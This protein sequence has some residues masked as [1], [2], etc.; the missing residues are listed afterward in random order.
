MSARMAWRPAAPARNPGILMIN[1]ATLV[2]VHHA[3]PEERAV[4]PRR[5][6]L[7]G[8]PARGATGGGLAIASDTLLAGLRYDR[9]WDVRTLPFGRWNEGETVAVKVLHQLVD[10]A[11][12]PFRLL[13]S[14]PALVHLQSSLDRRAVLRD[15]AFALATRALGV[16]LVVMWHGS[17]PDLLTTRRLPWRA[18][19]D[20]LLRLTNAIVLLSSEERAALV[21]H[22]RAPHSRVMRNGL[23]L[24]RYEA[25]SDLRTRLGLPVGAQLLL[26]ISRLIPAKGLLDVVAAMPAIAGRTAAHLLVVGDG[27]ARS[28]AQ[29]LA[30]E[31]G[32]E[33]RVHFVGSVPESETLEYY[34]GSDILVFPTYHPEGFPMTLFQAVASG[35]GVVTTPMRAAADYLREPDHCLFVRP[36]DSESIA[37]GVIRLL[38]DA[39]LLAHMRRNNRQLAQRFDMRVVAAEFGDLYSEVLAGLGRGARRQED[40]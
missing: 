28:A 32:V 9:R 33:A 20:L 6:L 14:R 21:A 31:R 15:V 16:P 4:A 18:L 13:R 7:L 40:R 37:A 2:D 3:R 5:R 10:L 36:R 24:A 27:P 38:E 11:R 30:S 39:D 12:Y 1:D 29:A 23:D 22:P 34:C 25:H 17:E 19:V 26:F 35:Q 8:G